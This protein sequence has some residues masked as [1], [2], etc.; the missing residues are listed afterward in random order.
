MRLSHVLC[1]HHIGRQIR[2]LWYIQ[3]KKR[4]FDISTESKL[5]AKG[6]QVEEA[7]E[8]INNFKRE[9]LWYYHLTIFNILIE[10]LK[11]LQLKRWPLFIYHINFHFLFC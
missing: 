4:P 6:I 11:C 5:L 10:Y 3:G 9:S 7:S 1:K 2:Y 8:I